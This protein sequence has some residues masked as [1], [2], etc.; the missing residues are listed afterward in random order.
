MFLLSQAA[1]EANNLSKAGMRTA[2]TEL[3]QAKSAN[4]TCLVGIDCGRRRVCGRLPGE[5][6]NRRS[7]GRRCS[8]VVSLRQDQTWGLQIGN[9]F[10]KNTIVGLVSSIALRR[11]DTRGPGYTYEEFSTNTA[12]VSS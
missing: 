2:K 6:S 10:Y 9:V 12:E 1:L 3:A 7:S 4:R 5:R 8:A 11:N